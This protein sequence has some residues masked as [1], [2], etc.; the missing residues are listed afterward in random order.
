[1]E[2]IDT[3]FDFRTDSQGKDPDSASRTLRN[4]HKILWSK[5]LLNDKYFELRDDINGVYL[6]HK[7]DL[8]EFFLSS[9]SITHTYRRW[10]RKNI[11]EIIAQIPL[12]E[13]EFF[14]GLSYTIGGFIIFPGNRI[15]GLPTI[16]QDRGV[17]L[18]INDRIDL[19]LECIRRYYLDEESP[20]FDTLKRYSDFFDLFVDFRGY[21]E[22]FLLQDLVSDDFSEVN[23][24]LP[25]SE[26]INDPLPN[27]I[28][29]YNIYKQ[30][31]IDFLHNRNKRI[32]AGH[33][34]R[35]GIYAV[36]N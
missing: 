27:D 9:D 32:E 29:E 4:Y 24:L 36:R 16:N 10:K 20:L 21:C 1:M 26:F 23:F 2:H 34:R 18:Y 25:F 30:N 14:F 7:S 31:T 3:T 35:D 33:C 15:N 13:M 12:D 28:T 22:Y 6:Y 19:T 11:P 5:Q 8:G 17:N